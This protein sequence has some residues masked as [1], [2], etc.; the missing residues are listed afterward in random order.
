M[1]MSVVLRQHTHLK[2]LSHLNHLLCAIYYNP[3]TTGWCRHR[4][5]LTI[6]LWG[7]LLKSQTFTI[8]ARTRRTLSWPIPPVSTTFLFFFMWRLVDC[9][10]SVII[11]HRSAVVINYEYIIIILLLFGLPMIHEIEESTIQFVAHP[12]LLI[13]PHIH[14]WHNVSFMFFA[15]RSILKT[16]ILSSIGCTGWHIWIPSFMSSST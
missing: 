3:V 4:G 2:V 16:N 5:G 13:I 15:T 10:V 14:H 11:S 12:D 9:G 1:L 7:E 6:M 8:T